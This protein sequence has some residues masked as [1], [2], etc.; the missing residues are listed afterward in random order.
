MLK[1]INIVCLIFLLNFVKID[2]LLLLSS[3]FSLLLSLLLRTKKGARRRR[4][5]RSALKGSSK[6]EIYCKD[7]FFALAFLRFGKYI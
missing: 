5:A 2:F 1:I 4:H 7:K 6:K 3:A